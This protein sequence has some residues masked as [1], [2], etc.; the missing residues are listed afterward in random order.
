VDTRFLQ[1]GSLQTLANFHTGKDSST[2]NSAQYIPNGDEFPPPGQSIAQTGEYYFAVYHFDDGGSQTNF[3]GRN[4]SL[5]VNQVTVN[6]QNPVALDD[7]PFSQSIHHTLGNRIVFNVLANDSDPDGDNLTLSILSGFSQGQSR[8]LIDA[9]GVPYI[10]YDANRTATG[11]DSLTYQISDGNGGTDTAVISLTYKNFPVAEDDTA[12]VNPGETVVINIGENDFDANGDELTTTG[13]TAPT[14]GTVTYTDNIGR[15]DR[16]LTQ[17]SLML[18][19]LTLLFMLFPMASPI[20][21]VRLPMVQL[22]LRPL[23]LPSREI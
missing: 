22:I 15:P 1:G 2:T 20:L 4:Y 3:D 14:K 13:Q 17:P 9:G 16:F 6:N 23:Q 10:N 19:A 7:G 18:Q 21:E 8:V 5:T 12:T 11:T